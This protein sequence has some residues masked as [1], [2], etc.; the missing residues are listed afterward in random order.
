MSDKKSTDSWA[1]AAIIIA[2]IGAV[3][4]L[5]THGHAWVLAIV[6]VVIMAVFI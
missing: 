2:V 4:Y 5:A 3:V 1:E 6:V